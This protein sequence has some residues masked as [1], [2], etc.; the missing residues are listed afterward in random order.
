MSLVGLSERMGRETKYGS[1][2]LGPGQY[3]S[4]HPNDIQ[5][6]KKRTRSV[7][8]LL[9]FGSGAP[10]D[11]NKLGANQYSPGPGFYNQQKAISSFHR[12]FMKSDADKDSYYLVQ[13]GALQRKLQQ[14]SANRQINQRPDITMLPQTVPGPG[15]YSPRQ[16]QLTADAASDKKNGETGRFNSHRQSPQMTDTDRSFN[17]AHA[18]LDLNRMTNMTKTTTLSE[19][20][21]ARVEI[22]AKRTIG[23]NPPPKLPTNR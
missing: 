16:Y 19:F 5:K 18:G 6:I 2:A 21:Q 15:Q 3:N 7:Q 11:L 12:E 17:A 20:I 8:P 10:K 22:K 14:F 1:G 23:K 13:N 4:V 9:A